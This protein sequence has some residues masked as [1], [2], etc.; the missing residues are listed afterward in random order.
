MSKLLPHANNKFD[1]TV[2]LEKILSTADHADI[3]FV[4]QVDLK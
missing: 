1:H 3:G 4:L 2:G